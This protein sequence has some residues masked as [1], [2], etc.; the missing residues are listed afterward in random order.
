MNNAITKTRFHFFS[1]VGLRVAENE[2]VFWV[3]AR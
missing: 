3:S 1:A 2:S